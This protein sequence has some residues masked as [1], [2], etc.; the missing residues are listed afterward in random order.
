MLAAE[1]DPELAVRNLKQVVGHDRVLAPAG[2]EQEELVLGSGMVVGERRSRI[3]LDADVV[4]RSVAPDEAAGVLVVRVG[5]DRVALP[6]EVGTPEVN[7]TV[8]LLCMRTWRCC[9]HS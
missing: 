4:D 2:D 7:H 9:S 1:H 8:S 5:L 3:E 6:G